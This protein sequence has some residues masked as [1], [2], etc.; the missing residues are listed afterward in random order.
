MGKRGSLINAMIREAGRVRRRSEAEQRRTA[1]EYRRNLAAIKRSERE[2][3][4]FRVRTER[5]EKQGYIEQRNDEATL[6][7]EELTLRMKEL[8]EILIKTLSVDD[9]IN[10]SSL[11]LKESFPEFSPPTEIAKPAHEP[12]REKYLL[13]VKPLGLLE[14]AIPGASKRHQKAIDDAEKEYRAAIEEH[15]KNEQQRLKSYNKALDEYEAAKREFEINKKEKDLEVDRFETEYRAGKPEA[16]SDY[17]TMVL[18]RSSYPDGFPQEFRIAFIPESKQ[19]VVDYELPTPELVPTV[20]EYRYVKSKDAIEEKPRKPHENKELYQQVVASVALRTCHELFESDQAR[21]IEA[22]VFMCF[23][24]RNSTK[25]SS[26]FPHEAVG[27]FSQF[28]CRMRAC[29]IR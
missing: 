18:E 29:F 17:F 20:S 12:E 22:V 11:K 24:K 7:T 2:S 23:V 6:K 16:I 14:K 25:K 27:I 21:H 9:A 19:I 3:E 15:A 10:F 26:K 8:H 28:F 13:K 5:E 1:V 4:R